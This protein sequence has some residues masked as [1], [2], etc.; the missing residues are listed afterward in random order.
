ML[1]VNTADGEYTI[2]ASNR[3]CS[4][5]SVWVYVLEFDSMP[6]RHAVEDPAELRKLASLDPV[7]AN[8]RMDGT[9]TIK[10]DIP[11]NVD[12]RRYMDKMT[13]VRSLR[14]SISR[15]GAQL[16]SDR[17]R[18]AMSE[19]DQERT[20]ITQEILRREAMLPKL[21]DS[22]DRATSQLQKIEMEFLFSGVVI[23]PDKVMAAADQE[24]VGEATSYTFTKMSMGGK[25]D[26]KIMDP[27]VVFDYTFKILPEGQFALDNT[28][29]AGLIYQIQIFG[30]GGKASVKALKGLSPVFE[31]VSPNGRYVYRVGLFNSYK[32]VLANLN[33]VKRVGF[34]N[35][36]I[37]AYLDGEEISVSKARTLEAEKTKAQMFYEVRVAPADGEI[38]S[39]IMEGIVQQSGGKDVAKVETEEGVVYFIIGPFAD[40]TKAQELAEFIKAMG[41][42]EVTFDLAGMEKE[43]DI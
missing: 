15:Y 23:D 17:N 41:I 30:G 19:D 27:P 2:F 35:A 33:S 18:Y 37:V 7:G 9:A 20:R 5:D 29:P 13:E 6:V 16:D 32:D 31:R 26:M 34:R 38:D 28:I 39:T 8:E 12:I 40:K 1:L 25:L 3:D 4:A 10:A 22:L 36:F 11:E 14:D 43:Q 24:I 42:G 21:Q